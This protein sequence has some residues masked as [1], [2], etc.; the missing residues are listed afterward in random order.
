MLDCVPYY[1][2][3]PKLKI[4]CVILNHT[5]QC[6]FSTERML[7]KWFLALLKSVAGHCNACMQGGGEWM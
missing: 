5:K 1:F 6:D 4:F 3:F 7:R 2:V